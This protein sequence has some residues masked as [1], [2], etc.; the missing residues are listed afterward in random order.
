MKVIP[1][2]LFFLF[3][4]IGF[5]QV[6][7][8]QS[9]VA[10]ANALEARQLITKA[11][12]AFDSTQYKLAGECAELA[13]Q[14]F[15]AEPEAAMALEEAAFWSGKA[16][17][18]QKKFAKAQSFF[19]E[20]VLIR[21][22]LE[23]EGSAKT[24]SIW[25]LLGKTLVR[26]GKYDDAI[27][28]M[29]KALEMQARFVATD[30]PDHADALLQMGF[31]QLEKSTYSEAIFYFQKAADAFRI[32]HG[33]RSKTFATAQ[34]KLAQAYLYNGFYK[35]AISGLEKVLS[36]QQQILPASHPDIARTYMSIG[37]FHKY[38]RRYDD[39]LFYFN[40]AL[41]ILSAQKEKDYN[42][43]ADCF[44]QIG[45][46]HL[47]KKELPTALVYFQKED[48]IMITYGED[49]KADYLY[50]CSDL[51]KAYLAMENYPE[52]VRWQTKALE[53]AQKASKSDNTNIAT[54]S[55][56]LG[57]ALSGNGQY[58]EAIGF[59][60][61]NE[62]ILKGLYGPDCNILYHNNAEMGH[63]YAKWYSATQ[64]DSLLYLSLD[65][66]NRAKRDVEKN[67]RA[68]V[69]PDARQKLLN[70]T[71]P[72][73]ERAIEAELLL[74][75]TKPED[76]HSLENA[77]QI[78]ERM[79][80]HLLL[81]ATQEADARH[82]A[83]I[84]DMEMR[85]D[86]MLQAKLFI[87]GKNRRSLIESKGLALSDSLVLAVD[88]K[89]SETRAVQDQ[90]RKSFEQKYP[91]YFRLKYALQNSSLAKTQQLLSPQQTLLEFFVGDASIFVFVVQPKN[92]RVVKI[93]R[94]FPLTAWVQA[95]REGISGYHTAA[96][97]TPAGYQSTVLQYA[98]AA[99]RL[100]SKLLAPIAESLTDEL[101]IVPG[102]SLYNLPFEALLSAAPTDLSN[103]GTYPFLLKKHAVH[104]AY[105][106]T[107]LHQ[108]MER[109][110]RQATTDG[111]LAFAPFYGEDTTS[112]TTLL[113][114]E[115]A[116]RLGFSALPFSGEEV[117]RA[118]TRYGGNSKVW[119][120]NA[121]SKQT[122][123]ELA[124][125]YRILHLATHGK[126]NPAAG[127]FSFLAFASPESENGLLSVGELYN[128]PVNADL[129]V[130][131]ACETGI[132]EQQRGEGVLSLARAFAFAGAKSIVASL[133]SV[134]DQ[135]TM[136]IMDNFYKEIKA[137]KPKNIALAN[138]KRSYLLQNPGL[139]AHPFF[140]A[141]FV[142]L[143]DM[144]AI[145]N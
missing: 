70:E 33:E 95:L 105:S 87:L 121:A 19:S 11:Q 71:L 1:Q 114:Q 41:D 97:K 108:M 9:P 66:F 103:F 40:Q 143:G 115:T 26:L 131:S 44:S 58:A 93:P 56:Y 4:G 60:Q 49:Q 5:P 74:S 6:F 8:A 75:K 98:D 80:G 85:Q 110:H 101:I 139:G 27:E 25:T 46:A 112:L 136:Q 64:Q 61:T 141:G 53:I 118:K 52:A 120:G 43:L 123:L 17:F 24:A 113:R 31:A 15:K 37:A 135:S 132:G 2:T 133:W 76:S 23:P 7:W 73:F 79:H 134:N 96:Q 28:A 89:I 126:A 88:T 84:P 47:Y 32:C 21:E 63:T 122:F 3:L 117:F 14:Y 100:Y 39:A 92:S 45:Q 38:V 34:E 51:G 142:A 67:L 127:E 137:G 124:A 106:A 10:P 102:E 18:A 54:L 35:E 72:Y 13:Y 109:K 82:F 125:K 99:Q 12:T 111:L 116:V 130:L 68:E 20:S 55:L 83:E 81:S 94:D 104:Y 30:H 144:T 36:I 78:S 62:R 91:D 129:V 145:K 69:L 140:W 22:N 138:A 59:F 48:S 50:T 29:Q 128:L 77:W 86:S 42:G 65:Y 90:L 119:L 16:A 107:M 57:R